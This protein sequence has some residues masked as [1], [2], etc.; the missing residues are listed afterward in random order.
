[1]PVAI[2]A[3]DGTTSRDAACDA[4]T[5]ARISMP[6]VSASARL[7]SSSRACSVRVV[8]FTPGR[9]SRIAP[10]TRRCGS[11][12]NV[13]STRMP[14]RTPDASASG[15]SMTA[16]SVDSPAIFASVCPGVT[17]APSRTFSSLTTPVSGEA[18]TI[19]V[20]ARPV[21]SRFAI[22]LSGI[23]SARIRARE[24]ASSASSIAPR[25][26]ARYSSCGASQSGTNSEAI[27]APFAMRCNGALAYNR[28]T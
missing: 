20:C 28:S 25:L 14:G 11:P 5:R 21:R 26:S 8:A 16:H 19:C 24:A 17:I 2:T 1:M 15:T 23:D 18:S 9:I 3:S 6:G 13:A 7:S 10:L 4:P 12:S 27:G 22:T